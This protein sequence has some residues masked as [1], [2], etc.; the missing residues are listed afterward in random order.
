[1]A[2]PRRPLSTNQITS[3]PSPWMCGPAQAGATCEVSLG[4][5]IASFLSAAPVTGKTYAPPEAGAN[6]TFT[7]AAYANPTGTG[8]DRLCL[9]IIRRCTRA[10]LP[11]SLFGESPR[12][13]ISGVTLHSFP[14]LGE[15]VVN[16]WNFI[17]GRIS[18]PKMPLLFI[19]VHIREG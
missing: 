16:F 5:L 15:A 8:W 7:Q 1:M 3:W 6:F 10:K 17:R 12:A 11:R 19:I 9:E 13:S 14:Y 4:E 2:T 18:P